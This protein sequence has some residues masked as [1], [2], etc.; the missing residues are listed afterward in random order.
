MV[1][2]QEL[3]NSP[4]HCVIRNLFTSHFQITNNFAD[5]SSGSIIICIVCSPCVFDKKL[6]IQ[7]IR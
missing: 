4:R 6:T 7:A 3:M 2:M 5:T 1:D